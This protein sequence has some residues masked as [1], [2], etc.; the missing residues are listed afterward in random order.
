MFFV[1]KK[2]PKGIGGGGGKDVLISL[3]TSSWEVN[4]QDVGQPTCIV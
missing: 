3:H 2:A 1:N 4:A